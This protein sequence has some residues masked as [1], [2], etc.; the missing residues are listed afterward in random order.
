MNKPTYLVLDTETTGLPPRAQ[1]GAPP[2]PADDPRQPRMAS[3][4]GIIA[5]QHGREISRHKFYSFPDGWSIDGTEAGRVNGLTDDFLRENG[6]P[7]SETLAFYSEQIGNGLIAVAF[8]KLFDLKILRG[9][10][11]RAGMP[12]LF[13]QTRAICTMNALDPYAD[14]GLCMSRPGFV[15]LSVACEF[16]GIVNEQ[17]HDAMADAEAARAILEI[18]IRDGRRPEPSVTYS[19]HGAARGAANA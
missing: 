8:N 4:S 17:A 18:L 10:L 13:E 7:V 16:F 1:R 3:F 14:E 6:V 11:R 19:K 15:K 5:D 2:I 9:E 12:D